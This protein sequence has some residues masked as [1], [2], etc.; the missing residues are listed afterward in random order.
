MSMWQRERN[1]VPDVGS[2]RKIPVGV[3]GATETTG[4]RL[5]ASLENHPWFQAVWLAASEQS[6]GHRYKELRWR[7][8]GKVP[9]SVAERKVEA[10]KP[11]AA[12][13]MFFRLSTR[14]SPA[15]WSERSRQPGIL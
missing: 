5:L 15:M 7:L 10:P 9:T 8:P 6:T 3:L 13:G 14:P 4:Q 11:G 12:P 1:A 2:A